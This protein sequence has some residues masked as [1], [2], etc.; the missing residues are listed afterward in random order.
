VLTSPVADEVLRALADPV[1]ARIVELLAG[2]QLCTCHLVQMTGARQT[3]LSNHLRV[4]REAGVV[5]AEPAGRYTYYR[6][7]PD[8]L[9]AVSAHYA[10]LA[11]RA[12][13]A[14]A[15]KRPCG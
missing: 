10:E 4:L 8:V 9:E 7:R 15:V 3:N 11:S 12:A 2:E 14:V 6:L 1:R 5:E 13:L